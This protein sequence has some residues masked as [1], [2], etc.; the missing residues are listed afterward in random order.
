MFRALLANLQELHKLHLVYCV[1][2]TLV[3]CT[4]IGVFHTIYQVSFVQD[5][6]KMRK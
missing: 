1:Y 6:L 2:V 4:R 5:L 3:S